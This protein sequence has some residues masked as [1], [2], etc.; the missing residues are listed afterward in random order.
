MIHL[1]AGVRVYLC[2]TACDMRK[3]VRFSLSSIAHRHELGRM[4]EFSKN[5]L[6][7]RQPVMA[8]IAVFLI[9]FATTESVS[10]SKVK[11]TNL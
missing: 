10:R 7:R 6:V 11:V 2:L 4:A 3:S 8:P 5:N 9:C 1:P